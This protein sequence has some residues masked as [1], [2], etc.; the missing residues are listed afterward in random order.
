VKQLHTVLTRIGFEQK[1]P[2]RKHGN[3]RS[4]IRYDLFGPK[5]SSVHQSVTVRTGGSKREIA[6]KSSN[7]VKSIGVLIEDGRKA[8]QFDAKTDEEIKAMLKA[9]VICSKQ[10][11]SLALAVRKANIARDAIYEAIFST[12]VKESLPIGRD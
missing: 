4:D 3:G 9:L 6:E 10:Q 7:A 1:N 2:N 12:G 5:G 11:Q 8:K